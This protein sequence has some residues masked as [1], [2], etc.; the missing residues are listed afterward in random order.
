MKGDYT[1]QLFDEAIALLERTRKARNATSDTILHLT[2]EEKRLLEKQVDIMAD[3]AVVLVTRIK[4][5]VKP[6]GETH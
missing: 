2:I 4:E 3:Y 5:D 6:D 1:D